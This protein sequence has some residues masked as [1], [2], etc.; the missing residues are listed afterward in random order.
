VIDM[1]R[2]LEVEAG[3]PVAARVTG[4]IV[5]SALIAAYGCSAPWT[6]PGCVAIPASISLNAIIRW[7][8]GEARSVRRDFWILRLKRVVTRRGGAA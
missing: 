3:F 5:T 7:T 8:E 6:I 2:Q 1:D 4:C